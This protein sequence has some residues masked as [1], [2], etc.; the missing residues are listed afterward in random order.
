M[1]EF[2]NTHFLHVQKINFHITVEDK[3]KK[4]VSKNLVS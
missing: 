1:A 3:L 4:K 2:M